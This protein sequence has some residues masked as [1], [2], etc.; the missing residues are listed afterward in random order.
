VDPKSFLYLSWVSLLT[1]LTL[2]NLLLLP[3]R[4][5]FMENLWNF[6]SVFVLFDYL[7]DISYVL[8]II[9]RRRYLIYYERQ[10]PVY[11]REDIRTHYT[12]GRLLL[13]ALDCRFP[14]RHNFIGGRCPTSIIWFIST[15][16]HG[17]VPPEQ[18]TPLCG[19]A[20]A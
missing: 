11:C 8:D 12:R 3:A 20:L 7:S 18:I 10:G 13:F 9:L 5:A 4:L 2:L 14:F 6:W 15:T 1:T 19:L 17:C 16:S